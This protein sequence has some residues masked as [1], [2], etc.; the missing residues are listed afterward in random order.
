M[1]N[2]ETDYFFSLVFIP[3]NV[4]KFIFHLSM[5]YVIFLLMQVSV[6]TQIQALWPRRGSS[7]NFVCISFENMK[8]ISSV[9]EMSNII[10]L[11]MIIIL[12]LSF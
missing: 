9:N 3:K 12:S 11:I 10:I 1:G 8:S 2:L 6:Q 4:N 7:K 5:C